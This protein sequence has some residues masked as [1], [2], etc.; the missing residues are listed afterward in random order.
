MRLADD[1]FTYEEL[2]AVKGLLP[3]RGRRKDFETAKS[4][5]TIRIAGPNV[6]F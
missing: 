6:S 3:G 5:A 4:N 1:A 2:K